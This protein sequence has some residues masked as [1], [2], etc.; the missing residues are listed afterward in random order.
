[1]AGGWSVAWVYQQ[2]GRPLDWW[3]S[4]EEEGKAFW[5]QAIDLLKA[6]TKSGYMEVQ[7]VAGGKS[8][9][10]KVYLRPRVQR[11]LGTFPTARAAANKVFHFKMGWI[12]PPPTPKKRRAR[13]EG[14]APR[15]RRRGIGSAGVQATGASVAVGQLELEVREEPPEGSLVVAGVVP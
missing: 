9:E 3:P 5:E 8:F 2:L 6:E 10:A 14:R 11:S 12:D 4:S 13:G 7:C 1:M 15:V